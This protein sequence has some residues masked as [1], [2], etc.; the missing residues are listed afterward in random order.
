M[1]TCSAFLSLFPIVPRRFVKFFER[2]D[3]YEKIRVKAI[4]KQSYLWYNIK[5]VCC[6]NYSGMPQKSAMKGG[7]SHENS[8][9]VRSVPY[10]GASAA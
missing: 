5:V 10:A 3:G 9:T 8:R 2:I 7:K 4:E 1:R 6:E